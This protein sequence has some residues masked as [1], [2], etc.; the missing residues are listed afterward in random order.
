MSGKQK[1]HC[2]SCGRGIGANRRKRYLCSKACLEQHKSDRK[3]SGRMGRRGR[4][5]A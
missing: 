5:P 3:R 4:R 2:M 1:V